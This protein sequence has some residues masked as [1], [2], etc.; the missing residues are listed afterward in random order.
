[1]KTVFTIV[2]L[3]LILSFQTIGQEGAVQ[4]HNRDAVFATPD[5]EVQNIYPNPASSVAIL[6]YAILDSD[7]E[8]KII[9]HDLLGSMTRDF[10]LN[11]FEKTLKIDIQ[12]LKEGV[13]FYT[14]NAD[15]EN[16]FTKKL[17]IKK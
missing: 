8:V 17:I 14:L 13:Y 11:P 7:K 10:P 5:L 6:N 12:D 3:Q 9:L 2:G 15:G 16:K 4:L 1:M